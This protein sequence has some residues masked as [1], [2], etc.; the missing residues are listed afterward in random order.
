MRIWD[1]PGARRFIDAASDSLRRGSNLVLR[2]PG[3]PPDGFDDALATAL[4]SDLHFGSL[5]VTELPLDDLRARYSTDPAQ[6][7]T[8]ADLCADERF[9]GRLVRLHG[10]NNRNWAPWS[11]FLS[12]YS[13]VG[14]SM[15]LIG[16]TLFVAPLIGI[17]SDLL[18]TS[19]VALVNRDWDNV[20]DD[21][22]ILLLADDALRRRSIAP[23]LRSLLSTTI[24]RVACGDF[25]TASRLLGEDV[26]TMLCPTAFLQ[27][28]AIDKS[29]T[30]E[31]PLSWTLGTQSLSGV[32][33]PVRAALDT[34][35][36]EIHRRVWS[37]QLSTL[38]PW[39]ESRRYETVNN[40][41]FEVNRQIRLSGDPEVDPY[42][43]EVG[44]LAKLF[45]QR[46][47]DRRVRR[48]LNHLRNVRNR[49]AH[50]QHL[51]PDTV[52]RLLGDNEVP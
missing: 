6:I 15:P 52:L 48:T 9:Q 3:P 35:P 20:L 8:L 30:A 31:T 29:W 14:R 34:P 28:V 40:H 7:Q 18:P 45:S 19:D 22:D 5:T 10:L 21:V 50:R 12:R 46:G 32:V 11:N 24:A 51:Q 38:L 16:R 23:L 4:G 42:E 27:R 2:F 17:P 47:A 44:E 33:H 13:E 49:L 26:G 25:E 1:L 37:A 39:I 36:T 43:L 41:L